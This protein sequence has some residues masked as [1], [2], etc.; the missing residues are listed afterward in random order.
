MA[1]PKT[2]APFCFERRCCSGV[3]ALT[4]GVGSWSWVGG[5]DKD[6]LSV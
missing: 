6:A 4:V 2:S 3:D 1:K 5:Q